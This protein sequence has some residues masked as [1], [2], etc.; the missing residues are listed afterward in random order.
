MGLNLDPLHNPRSVHRTPSREGEDQGGDYCDG[1]CAKAKTRSGGEEKAHTGA[2][3][4]Y[5]KT[6]WRRQPEPLNN[7]FKVL[8]APSPISDFNSKDKLILLE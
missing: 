7:G 4:R 2:G 6:T 3:N 5:G 1:A 8:P